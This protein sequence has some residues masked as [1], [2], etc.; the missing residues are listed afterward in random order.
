MKTAEKTKL[1][2]GNEMTWCPGCTNYLARQ[3]VSE[4]IRELIEEGRA[5]KE[6][7]VSVSDI[8]CSSKMYDYLNISGINGL[9][10]RV[11]PIAFGVKLG[12]PNLKV[13]G[14]AGDGGTYN[15]GIEHLIH[16]ARYNSDFTMIVMNNQ[17]FALTVGQAT[18]V[19]ESGFIEKTNP[20]GVKEKPLNPIALVLESGAGFVARLNVFDLA[21][22]KEVIKKAIMHKGFAFVEF[23]QPCI[24]F[25][26]HSD[27]IKQNSYKIESMS[28]EKALEKAREWDYSYDGKKIPVGIFFDESEKS[29]AEKREVLA[30][31]I[32]EKKGFAEIGN[33][34]KSILGEFLI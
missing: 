31:L 2:T 24:K 14:F 7:F 4:A 19:T 17:I 9:H 34:K 8:G 21:F 25:H 6:D 29:F 11:L 33:K 16:N 15:E 23:L 13:L 5:K 28:R 27:Y 1:E 12:N 3:A 32:K 22:N 18:A 10:G 26:N 20:F 30:R